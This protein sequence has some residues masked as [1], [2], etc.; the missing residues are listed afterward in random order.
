MTALKTV[1][2]ILLV[3]G[4]VLVAIPL[5][6]ILPADLLRFD[7]G[8]LRWLA[9]P[10]WLLG[11]VVLCWCAADF[12][13]KGHGTPAPLEPPRELVIGGLYRFTRNPMYVGVLL[14]AAGHPFWF[15]SYG[16]A[17]Y[18]LFLGLVFHFFVLVYEEPH[19]RKTFGA[20]Y[21]QYCG[22]VPRWI[23]RLW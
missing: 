9:L 16:L 7:P 11:L 13:R 5:W 2:F 3:P 4:S 8:L 15:G 14:T 22:S 20:A 19:L 21:E 18:V 17:G 23:P 10:L 1:L 6:W 12:V